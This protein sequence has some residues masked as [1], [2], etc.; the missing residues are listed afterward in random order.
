M[1]FE[2]HPKLNNE[3]INPTITNGWLNRTWNYLGI[4]KKGGIVFPN[5]EIAQTTVTR[6]PLSAETI[7]P[8]K[9]IK[10]LI[11]EIQNL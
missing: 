4:T 6:V 8:I 10:R 2:V 7:A 9:E 5:A 11:L 3:S 1:G